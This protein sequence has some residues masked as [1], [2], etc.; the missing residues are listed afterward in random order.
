[1]PHDRPV[2]L[3]KEESDPQQSVK[4]FNRWYYLLTNAHVVSDPKHGRDP[5][6]LTPYQACVYFEGSDSVRA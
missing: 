6:S 5:M 1:M 3:S 2:R 4:I